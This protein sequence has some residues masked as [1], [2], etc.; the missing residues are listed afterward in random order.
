MA[1][2]LP[3]YLLLDVSGSMIGEPITAVQ[4]GVQ[5]MVSALMG[6]PQALESAY[7]SVITFSN[8][9]EQV[10]P[11]TELSQ[12]NPPPL[13]AGGMTSLGDALKF[14]AQCADR[15]VVKNTPAVKG[16]WKPLV[17]IMTDGGA[18][19]DVDKGL[20]EFRKKKWGIVVACG[21]GSGADT[22]ELS[23]ITEAVVSLDTTDSASIAAFFKWVSASVSTSSKSVGAAN[24]EVSSLDQLPPPPPEIQI[25]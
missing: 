9:A 21:A 12:F 11:L 3:V 2:R 14:V 8:S 25:L 22:S 7:L 16:D 1:R 18:T 17:F 23:K 6:D 19:D 13:K 15:E 20:I 24:K 5:T 10:V 4:N